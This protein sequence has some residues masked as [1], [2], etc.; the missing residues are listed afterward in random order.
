MQHVPAPGVANVAKGGE[1]GKTQI[2]REKDRFG[3]F[4]AV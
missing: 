1:R 2:G 3:I 4:F